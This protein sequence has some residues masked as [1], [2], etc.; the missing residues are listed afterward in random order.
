[1]PFNPLVFQKSQ[2]IL[3]HFSYNVF[4]AV[5]INVIVIIAVAHQRKRPN[6]WGKRFKSRLSGGQ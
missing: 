2:K 6:Y 5:E 3:R 4:Y 1:M